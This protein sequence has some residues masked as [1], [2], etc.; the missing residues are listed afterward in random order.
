MVGG[1]TSSEGFRCVVLT[2]W[3]FTAFIAVLLLEN[4]AAHG[5]VLDVLSF[6]DLS[7]F[8]SECT[9]NQYSQLLERRKLLGRFEGSDRLSVGWQGLSLD[10]R[11]VNRQLSV[12]EILFWLECVIEE[13]ETCSISTEEWHKLYREGRCCCVLPK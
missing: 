6:M 11:Q 4:L 5:G 9:A 3:L 7:V 10:H 1:T 12:A 8:C 2:G 13:D